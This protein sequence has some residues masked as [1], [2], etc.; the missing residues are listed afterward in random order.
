[1]NKVVH[2][3]FVKIMKNY[4]PWHALI[5]GENKQSVGTLKVRNG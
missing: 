5:L 4:S 1:M 2:C 3:F